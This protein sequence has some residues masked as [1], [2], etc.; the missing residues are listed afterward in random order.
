MRSEVPQPYA[1]RADGPPAGYG[2]EGDGPVGVG[3]AGDG[4]ADEGDGDG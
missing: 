3:E 2:D 1:A 4:E